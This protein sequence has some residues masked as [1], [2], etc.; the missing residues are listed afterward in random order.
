MVLPE[1][2]APVLVFMGKD[3]KPNAQKYFDTK[4]ISQLKMDRPLLYLKQFWSNNFI[5][6]SKFLVQKSF[7]S[8]KY[9]KKICEDPCTHKH[10]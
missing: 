6:S 3:L 4:S 2:V 7:W 9:M 10:V 1:L 8:K 5:S